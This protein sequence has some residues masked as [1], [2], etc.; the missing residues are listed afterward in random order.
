MMLLSIDL[1]PLVSTFVIVA[2]AE[3]GDKTQI[4]VISLSARQRPRAV[5]IGAILAFALVD[6]VITLISSDISLFVP[7]FWI[8]LVAGFSFVV[9][10]VYTVLSKEN[11]AVKIKK[12]SNVTFT[13]FFLVS[14]MEFGDKA[15]LAIIALSAEYNSAYSSIH[16]IYDRV[17]I[18]DGSWRGS[19]QY[20]L[21]IHVSRINKNWNRI[22]I[23][24]VWRPFVI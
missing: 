20:S 12:R 3:F 19:W 16:R 1:L 9:F 15:Q 18:V 7:S 4:A 21:S 11:M 22:S 6:G 17:C 24:S 10:G 5:F 14:I 13:S 23:P 8:G 2:L